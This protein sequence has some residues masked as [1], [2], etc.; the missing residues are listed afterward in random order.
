MVHTSWAGCS[1]MVGHQDH[2]FQVQSAGAEGQEELAPHPSL[3]GC[4]YLTLCQLCAMR[5]TA[6][7]SSRVALNF[8][9]VV[10]WECVEMRV[11]VFFLVRIFSSPR[12]PGGGRAGAG[13]G[14]EL[15]RTF[16]V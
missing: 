2:W 3:P 11:S 8:F 16:P 10:I 9:S 14:A 15:G 5:D 1:F 7:S 6:G 4:W 12:L 13:A